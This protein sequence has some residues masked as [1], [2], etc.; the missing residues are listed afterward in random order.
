M[1]AKGA[2]GPGDIPPTFIKS[3]GSRAKQ[4]LLDIFNLSSSTG[5][6]PQIC[7]IAIILPL[8]KARKPPGHISSYR[9]H[10]LTVWQKRW[11]ESGTA[12]ARNKRASV[13]IDHANTRSC[14]SRNRSVTDIR[15][16]SRRGPSWRFLTTPRHLT[17]SGSK[18]CLSEQLTKAS[19]LLMLSGSATFSPTEKSTYRSTGSEADSNHYAR[20][21]LKSLSSR[22]SSS[23]CTWTTFDE[24]YPKT[25]R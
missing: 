5:K 9:P 13:R 4:E 7:K 23:Y 17:V 16:P 25:L 10:S 1:P 6:S 19:R 2:P 24:S 18:T 3:L 14:A 22:R 21:S 8:K 20:D 15:P 12:S 11:N